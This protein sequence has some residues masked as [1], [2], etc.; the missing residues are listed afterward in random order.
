MTP[1]AE[2]ARPA[3]AMAG[4]G[5]DPSV[6]TARVTVSATMP[7]RY[8]IPAADRVRLTGAPDRRCR[9]DRGCSRRAALFTCQSPQASCARAGSGSFVAN[10]LR[11]GAGSADGDHSVPERGHHPTP[12]SPVA[13]PV[14]AEDGRDRPGKGH[15][16]APGANGEGARRTVG[17]TDQVA[18]TTRAVRRPARRRRDEGRM[19]DGQPSVR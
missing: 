17:P 18:M 13:G 2:P 4:D 8:P 1:S 16:A 19:V 12:P 7:D 5:P 14:Q 11:R 9:A 10:L 6:S 15:L 3:I